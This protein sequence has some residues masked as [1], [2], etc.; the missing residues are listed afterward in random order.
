MT[1][2]I[3]F[4]DLFGSLGPDARVLL[5]F[6]TPL[7]AG[8]VLKPF[9]VPQPPPDKPWALTTIADRID[10]VITGVGKAPAA[11]AVAAFLAANRHAGVLNLGI[12]GSL[13]SP[14]PL[15]LGSLIIASE[16]AFPDEGVALPQTHLPDNFLP[17]HTMGFAPQGTNNGAVPC[18]PVWTAILRRHFP[19]AAFA[20][21]ATVSTCSGTD[22]LAR[23]IATRSNASA[24]CMEGAAVALAARTLGHHY[25]ELRTISNTTGD[26][27]RQVWDL[28]G[29]L[30]QLASLLAPTR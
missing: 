16:H 20:P 5:A 3:L 19:A 21:I 4:R 8:A 28:R 9:L 17:L 7:E 26:R 27:P 25:A 2:S 15:P 11:A 14:S 12:A 13:P 30:E 6:A 24:E 29:A 10:L 22:T 1:H 23:A 18:D